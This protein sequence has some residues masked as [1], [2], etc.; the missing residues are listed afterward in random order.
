MNALSQ[1]E[2]KRVRQ[3]VESVRAPRGKA[4]KP[5]AR[6]ETATADKDSATAVKP[7][8]APTR[9]KAAAKAPAKPKA[10]AKAKPKAKAAAG[11]A[12]RK[13]E[14]AGAGK[15]AAP[16]KKAEKPRKP[17]KPNAISEEVRRRTKKGNVLTGRAK[18][19]QIDIE[20]LT[21][22]SKKRDVFRK[23]GIE[24]LLRKAPEEEEEE[25]QERRPAAKRRRPGR[26]A[27]GLVRAKQRPRP[28]VTPKKPVA[29]P[30][31]V[32]LEPPVTVKELSSAIGVKA[33]TIISKLMAGGTMAT[34]NQTLEP[35]TAETVALEF[36]VELEIKQAVD[37]EAELAAIFEREDKP[38][39]REPRA[40]VVA[41]LGH[42]DHGKTTLLDAIRKT[43]VAAGEAGGITQHIGAYKV[44]AGGREVVF[45]DTPGHEAFTEMRARGANVTDLVVLVVAADDGVMPQTEE[46]VN[47]ARA[48][49]V[50]IVVAVSKVDKPDAN[51]LRTK[52]QLAGL[53]LNPEEWGGQTVF[54]EVSGITGQ[55]LDELVEMLALEAELL[56]LQAARNR[57][58]VGVV[59]E[60][61]MSPGRGPMATLLVKNGTLRRGDVILAG[62][63][64]GRVREL[65]D[66]MMR[67]L[68]SA[69]AATPVS[70]TGLGGLPDAGDRFYVLD[71]VQKAREIAERRR[72]RSRM[73]SLSERRHVTLENLY[74]RI[75]EGEVKSLNIILKTDVQGSCEVLRKS[76]SK[77]SVDEVRVNVLHAATGGITRSDVALA[78]ASDA[79]IVG[80][81]V[82]ADEGARLLAEEKGVQVK[83]YRVIYEVTD[84]I[85]RAMEG[86]LQPEE[87]EEVIGHMRVTQLFKMSRVG[88]VGGGIVTRGR[89]TRTA[90]VRLIRDNVVIHEG[91]I[92]SLRRYKDDV[93]E[94]REGFECG[95]KIDGYDD[96][97]VD[98][99]IEAFEIREIARKL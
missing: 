61:K 48:A 55:G 14:A 90:G 45:L 24:E 62:P 77:L 98:D 75:A 9:P 32:T 87:V 7:R 40:P 86:M 16:P 29:R 18:I 69:H 41:F 22:R 25:E 1:D 20:E 58:A 59:L 95:L 85:R 79:I 4:A 43:H 72:R 10:R 67:P 96:I 36:G 54:V 23:M 63:A 88:T 6:K 57:P 15:A 92:A 91:K 2:E 89:L 44:V 13:A 76:I 80:F 65:F 56:E 53:G 21:K 28:S 93:R 30:T 66:D 81:S 5:R 35:A 19:G 8:K 97:K 3:A 46:A 39:D 74:S 26:P 31:R 33:T 68:S 27:P 70:V 50:P 17:R 99:I 42:V 38:E 83:L 94:V 51:P 49:G 78:D 64:W 47:H 37:A 73:A 84:S 71:D 60:A 34:I 82:V 11:K 12:L 52:Q